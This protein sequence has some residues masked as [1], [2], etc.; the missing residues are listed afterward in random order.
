MAYAFSVAPFFPQM[1]HDAKAIARFFKFRNSRKTMR[2]ACHGRG[3]GQTTH[4]FWKLR[5][6]FGIL[7][8]PPEIRRACSLSFKSGCDS[9]TRGPGGFKDPGVLLSDSGVVY[10][11]PGTLAKDPGVFLK[12][13]G[14]LLKAGPRILF[15]S[16]TRL[17][18]FNHPG[19]A[20]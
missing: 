15:I 13:P 12:D 3:L 20:S 6:K 19:S 1:L 18:F 10:K 17:Q 11:N 16:S 4:C 14:V 5:S 8:P 7:K 9:F 2:I